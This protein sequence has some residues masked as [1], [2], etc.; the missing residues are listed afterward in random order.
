MAVA[1]RFVTHVLPPS[2]AG[3]A[4]LSL[5]ALAPACSSPA[6]A[7]KL[8]TS[9]ELLTT[10]EDEA[11]QADDGSEA[12]EEATSGG[13]D[14]E[15]GSAGIDPAVGVA[16]QVGKIKT[17]PGK[18]FSPAGCIVTTAG[19]NNTFTHVFTNCTGVGGR[20]YSGTVTATWTFEAK[21]IT[22]KREAKGFK[23]D[24][25]TVDRTVTVEYSSI[26][27]VLQR[28]RTVDLKGTTAKGKD[29]TRKAAWTVKWDATAKCVSRQGDAT[30]T[31]GDRQH[32]TKIEGYKRCGVG[33]FGCPESGK[34]T[35]SRAA[36]G[37]DKEIAIVIELLGGR[38]MSIT[39][40]P[41]TRKI[42]RLLVCRDVK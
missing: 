2:L 37:A 30:T 38:R 35:L 39:L 23:V 9:E 24:G 40:P 26:A 19:A 17:N 29:F 13:G 32:A 7:E 31:F 16:D 15:G 36:A 27:N 1:R 8:S 25:A 22:V 10:D 41:T 6:P 4:A 42:E 21:K 3:L 12:E 18:F 33:S 20:T 14:A 28:V 34:I 11:A 5:V